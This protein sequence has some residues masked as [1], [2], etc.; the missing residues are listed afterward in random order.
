MSFLNPYNFIRPLPKPPRLDDHG[1]LVSDNPNH[2]LLWR[3]PPPPHDRFT[4]L[5][6]RITCTMEA[7]TPIFISDSEIVN[8]DGRQKKHRTYKFFNVDGQD[9]IPATSLRGSIRSLFEA[10]TNSSFGVFSDQQLSYRENTKNAQGLIP[11]YVEYDTENKKWSVILLTGTTEPDESKKF[12]PKQGQPVF[13]AWVPQYRRNRNEN[14]NLGNLRHGSRCFASMRLQTYQRGRMTFNYWEV[15]A[16]G[17]RLEDVNPD[18][19]SNRENWIVEQGLLCITNNNIN[20]KHDE[21]FFFSTLDPIQLPVHPKVVGRYNE[22]LKQ[23]REFHN[24]EIKKTPQN[25]RNTFSRFLIEDQ[26]NELL[27]PKNPAFNNGE[28]YFP[29]Y[30]KLHRDGKHGVR[31]D[32]IAPVS[33]PRVPEKRSLAEVLVDEGYDHLLPSTDF[34]YLSPA[35]RVFG[36]VRQIAEG[37]K[38][39]NDT[40]VAYRGRVRF[41]HA[42]PNDDY[43]TLRTLPLSILSSPKP[44]TT[45]FYVDPPNGPKDGSQDNDLRYGKRGNMLRGRKAYRHHG[46]SFSMQEAQRLA[47]AQ[48]SDQNRS[49][50]GAHAA[51]TRYKF[52]IEFENL[53]PVELGALLWTL[54]LQDEGFQGHHRIGF[55][56]PL[57]FGS[58]AMIEMDLTVRSTTQRYLEH[59]GDGLI[60]NEDVEPYIDIFKESFS[61]LYDLPFQN[62]PNIR[63]IQRLLSDPSSNLPIHYPRPNRQ[64]DPEG[65]NFQWFGA[66]NRQDGSKMMLPYPEDD[67]NGFPFMYWDR[68]QKRVIEVR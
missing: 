45:R 66:N 19:V 38:V 48:N 47:E 55:A 68:H 31:V 4:G 30:V 41:S 9:I 35:D 23:M 53:Q 40:S 16:V 37:E 28:S 54:R 65:R 59:L 3:C 21:R 43:E 58:L 17:Q 42:T 51:G 2:H 24:D 27:D 34:F 11:G 6:G 50:V 7:Q 22:S 36:W 39:S 10:V 61:D 29:V 15:E 63:D 33:I 44:T 56:K 32:Y 57:G 26:R 46:R 13:A 49:V 67:I 52:T 60:M 14:I 18:R 20:R 64:R 8:E 1:N 25:R 5:S 12:I 62:L